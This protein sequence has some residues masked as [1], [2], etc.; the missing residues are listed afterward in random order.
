MGTYV[1]VNSLPVLLKRDIFVQDEYSFSGLCLG[2][3]M[4]WSLVNTDVEITA[5][6]RDHRIQDD[7]LDMTYFMFVSGE[8]CGLTQLNVVMTTG[9]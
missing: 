2:L 4:S 8:Q 7:T 6:Y 1:G 3:R 9:G 5:K